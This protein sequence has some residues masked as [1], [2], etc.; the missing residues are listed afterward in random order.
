MERVMN[1]KEIIEETI[2]ILGMIELPVCQAQAIT[3]IQ[4]SMKNLG[5]VL[6]M[7]EAEENAERDEENGNADTE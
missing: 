4:G 3:A 1:K 5:I 2:N 6:N 7:I